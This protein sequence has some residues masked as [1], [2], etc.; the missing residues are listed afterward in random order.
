MPAS[1]FS[2]SFVLGVGM[3]ESVVNIQFM[4]EGR[5]ECCTDGLSSV[6]SLLEDSVTFPYSQKDQS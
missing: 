2:K 5:K 3:E 4:M 6:M 1:C